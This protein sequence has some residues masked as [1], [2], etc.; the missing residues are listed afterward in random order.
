MSLVVPVVVEPMFNRFSSMSESP[1][2]DRLMSVVQRSGIQVEDILVADASRRT[3]A[4]NAYVS[5]FAG[6]RRVVVYDTMVAR[7]P[8]DQIAMVTAHELGHVAH[9]DVLRNT[10][11][12]A[13]WM[14]VGAIALVAG[15]P[16]VAGVEVAWLLA[17]T[18]L[19]S[20]V[21]APVQ[22]AFSRAVE[23]SADDYALELASSPQEVT[24][25]AQVQRQLA[26]DNVSSL[27]PLRALYLMYATHPLAPERIQHAREEMARRGWGLLPSMRDT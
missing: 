25:F 9:H 23:R 16:L 15:A 13:L 14:S 24:A 4:L 8:E 22:S 10:A 26:I 6:T 20:Q 2:R 12:A 27:K 18:A 19:A 17:V 11:V 1:L 5:G 21:T 7:V 3:T